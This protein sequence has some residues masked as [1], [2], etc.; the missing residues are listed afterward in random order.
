MPSTRGEA[1]DLWRQSKRNPGRL[2]K[3]GMKELERYLAVRAGAEAD[4]EDGWMNH[5]MLAYVNQVI[6][7]QH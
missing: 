3:E 4:E 7:A 5:R 6:L 1:T 2:F